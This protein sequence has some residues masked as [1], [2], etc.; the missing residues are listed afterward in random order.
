MDTLLQVAA[1]WILPALFFWFLFSIIAMMLIEV[2]QRLR[3]S[4]QNGLE[5]VIKELL[6]DKY[7]TKFY[8]HALVNPL[9]VAEEDEKGDKK[10]NKKKRKKK[11]KRPS[12]ISPS[13]FA[14]V[15]MDWM[16]AKTEVEKPAKQNT[17]DI[18]ITGFLKVVVDWILGVA[19]PA[20]SDTKDT[21]T[22][23]I[24]KNI[25]AI[26]QTNKRLG[27]ILQS[28]V[29]QADRKTDKDSEFL[30]FIQKDLEAWFLEAV[31]QMHSVYGARL[32]GITILM[33]FLVAAAT[34]FDLVNITVRLWET[35]KYSELKAL[36]LNPVVNQALF[37][38]L[39]VGW[40]SDNLPSSWTDL[41]IKI[42][43]IFLGAFFIA[44]GSQYVFNL[45]KKQYKPAKEED[46]KK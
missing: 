39:P 20:K 23:T 2:F 45:M 43:G 38:R 22:E 28:I 12:Y 3:K 17:V 19:Q 21:L 44:I 14:K 8:Q 13:L 40:Y 41:A 11:D 9:E 32:Q 27:E 31:G 6:G 5:E 30:D 7:A 4:R 24:Q 10:D 35:S 33:S 46:S 37:T 1:S 25:C 18:S 36:G 29:I 15:I 26:E 16:L 34:N 42:A